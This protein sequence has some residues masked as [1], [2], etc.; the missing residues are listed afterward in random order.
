[1]GRDAPRPMMRRAARVI[2]PPVGPALN[3]GFEL[4]GIA[5]PTFA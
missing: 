2:D 4:A 1:M 3:L 5:G